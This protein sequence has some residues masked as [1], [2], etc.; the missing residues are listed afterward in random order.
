MS[1]AGQDCPRIRQEFYK[2][3]RIK[4]FTNDHLKDALSF[5]GRLKPA[6]AGS[7]CV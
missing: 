7:G 3:A 1:G 6:E 4:N 5:S 2:F